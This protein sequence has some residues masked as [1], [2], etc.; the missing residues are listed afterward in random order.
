LNNKTI[1]IITTVDKATAAGRSKESSAV[2]SVCGI[3]ATVK[4]AVSEVP[5][6]SEAYTP[7]CAY[8]IPLQTRF[9]GATKSS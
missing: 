1:P 5:I 2:L 4:F 3:S 9:S 7:T 8:A 6:F